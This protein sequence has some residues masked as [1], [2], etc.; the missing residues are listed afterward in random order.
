VPGRPIIRRRPGAACRAHR[1]PRA[2]GLPLGARRRAAVE[3]LRPG[4]DRSG[5]RASIQRGVYRARSSAHRSRPRIAVG[6]GEP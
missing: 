6:H 5:G 4:R 3:T 1:T 2:P